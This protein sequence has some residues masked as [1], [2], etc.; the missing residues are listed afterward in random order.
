[1]EQPLP[2]HKGLVAQ[3]PIPLTIPASLD[4]PVRERGVAGVVAVV[5]TG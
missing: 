5:A 3:H 4:G 2:E 1:M